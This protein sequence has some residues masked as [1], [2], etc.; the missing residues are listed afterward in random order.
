MYGGIN[1]SSA[2]LTRPEDAIPQ[3]VLVCGVDVDGSTEL[4]INNPM[5]GSSAILEFMQSFDL[6]LRNL[7]SIDGDSEK[8]NWF[9]WR[10]RGDELVYFRIIPM[11]DDEEP[12][13][14]IIKKYVE[15]FI[16]AIQQQY[17]VTTGSSDNQPLGLHGY[18][19]LLHSKREL[20]D[21][22][23][24]FIPRRLLRKEDACIE[25][26]KIM[27]EAD[28][29][30]A[31]QAIFS[32]FGGSIREIQ[33]DYFV[34]FIGREVDLGFRIAEYS[35]PF[36]FVLSPKLAR[37]ILDGAK[38]TDTEQEVLLLGFYEMKGCSIGQEGP[39]RFPLCFLPIENKGNSVDA[40]ILENYQISNLEEKLKKF[41]DYENKSCEANYSEFCGFK[42]NKLVDED[43]KDLDILQNVGIKSATSSSEIETQIWEEKI[44]VVN[45][46]LAIL[47]GRIE[48]LKARKQEMERRIEKLLAN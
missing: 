17:S 9:L 16:D 18:A 39:D 2:G 32:E 35:R 38:E 1:V 20:W 37:C 22:S 29:A 4:K 42:N 47:D 13:C 11:R 10:V 28:R 14:P 46:R 48:A 8:D 34:D 36:Q 15:Q 6:Y 26:G 43:D 5:H 44:E 3:A 27:Y 40:S 30:R 19:F 41:E 33:E 24:N 12:E 45:R 23:W 7:D 31:N 25:T 21:F